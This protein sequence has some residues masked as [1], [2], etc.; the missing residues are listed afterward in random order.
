MRGER[1]RALGF[2]TGAAVGCTREG[3]TVGVRQEEGTVRAK[4]ERIQMCLPYCI[5]GRGEGFQQSRIHLVLSVVPKQG[6]FP[7]GR[8]DQLTK[9][10]ASRTASQTAAQRETGFLKHPSPSHQRG[11]RRPRPLSQTSSPPYRAHCA[12]SPKAQRQ[13]V[14]PPHNPNLAL[15]A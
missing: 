4:R 12:P 11:L 13:L 10:T 3:V 14:C 7:G 1:V 8:D 6:C 5:R 9:S 2:G 15:R